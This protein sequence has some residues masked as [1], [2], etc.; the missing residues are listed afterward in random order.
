MIRFQ[1]LD[2]S[3][4]WESRFISDA[5]KQLII[6]PPEPLSLGRALDSLLQASTQ[7]WT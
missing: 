5:V 6:F 1:L 3:I 2:K 7:R 4:L